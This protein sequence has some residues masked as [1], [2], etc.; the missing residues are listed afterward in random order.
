MAW[1][2]YNG[3]MRRLNDGEAIVGGSTAAAIHVAGGDLLPRHFLLRVAGDESGIRVWSPDS[4]VAINGRQI[5]AQECKLEDGDTISAGSIHFHIW[6]NEPELP[7]GVTRESDDSRPP[8][9][10][11]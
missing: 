11:L 10:H 1:L 9:A 7:A 3:R 6:H 2:E 5:A 8:V 4:V